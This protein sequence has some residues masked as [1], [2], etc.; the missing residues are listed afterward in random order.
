MSKFSILG[1]HHEGITVLKA[2]LG[3]EQDGRPRGALAVPSV[4]ARDMQR[5]EGSLPIG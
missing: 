2:I 5:S 1:F 3:P 4:R